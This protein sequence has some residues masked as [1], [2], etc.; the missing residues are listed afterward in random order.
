[1]SWVTKSKEDELKKAVERAA[2]KSSLDS[3]RRPTLMFCST[4]D[5]GAFAG[6]V[7][8]VDYTDSVVSVT[9]TDSWG[10]LTSKSDRQKEVDIK[11]PGEDL[12]A[13]AP[14]YLVNAGTSV[15][16]SS[17]ATALA[18][19]IASLALLLLR[20]YNDVDEEEFWP[21]YTRDGIMRVFNKMDASK[22][23]LQVQHLFPR[24]PVDPSSLHADVMA[25]KWNI[26]NF[27]KL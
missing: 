25:S 15:S 3:K 11:I 10:G 22:G 12:E 1:M 13:S 21:F 20:A 9:A 17:V 14:A 18:A 23:A 24:D 2:V 19:G 5:E 4:A 16:G 8:P 7:Y 26:S 27:P 6:D